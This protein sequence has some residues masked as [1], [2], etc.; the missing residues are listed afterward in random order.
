MSIPPILLPMLD[1]EVA[2]LMAGIVEEAMLISMLGSGYVWGRGR[3][4]TK[5]KKTWEW[6]IERL[7]H[8]H[9][10][11]ER[12]RERERE[13]GEE[14]KSIRRMI[15]IPLVLSDRETAK[16]ALMCSNQLTAQDTHSS[17]RPRYNLAL[18]CSYFSR[19]LRFWM[20][21]SI[22]VDLTPTGLYFAMCARSL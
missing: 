1:V 4:D 19:I 6:E 12:E 11:R 14:R 2:E 8:T 22:I 3:L 16:T 17:P 13:G 5:D 18:I 9:T 15:L 7:T 10:D 20:C 21:M